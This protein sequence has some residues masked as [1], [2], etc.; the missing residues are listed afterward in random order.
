MALRRGTNGAPF[1]LF[2][3][4]RRLLRL[5]FVQADDSAIDT[6]AA[7]V[8]VVGYCPTVAFSGLIRL[9]APRLTDLL[10][11]SD[12]VELHDVQ[13][14]RRHQVLRSSRPRQHAWLTMNKNAPNAPNHVRLAQTRSLTD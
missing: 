9:S 6:D 3:L 8:E 1:H 14:P 13:P 10:N 2:Q 5:D 12:E 4:A 11:R 7:L